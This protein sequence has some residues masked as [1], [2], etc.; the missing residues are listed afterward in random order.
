ML[1]L[2]TQID[3]DATADEVWSVLADNERWSQWNPFIVS[4][5]GPLTVGSTIVNVMRER[6][7]KERTFRPKVLVVDFGR[8][9]R[10]IGRLFLPGIF[11]GEHSFL[12]EPTAPTTVRFTQ[13]ET[14]QGILVPLLRGSLETDA[15]AQFEALNEALAAEVH[16]RRTSSTTI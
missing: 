2:H 9:L 13:E 6:S 7:G 5:T 12:I 4:S 10:W 14:F 11:D 3:I 15:K 8:E 16:R 1:H